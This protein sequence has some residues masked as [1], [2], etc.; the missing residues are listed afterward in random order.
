MCKYIATDFVASFWYPNLYTIIILR[1][2]VVN[3]PLKNIKHEKITKHTNHQLNRP[4]AFNIQHVQK[5]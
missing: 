3:T 2:Q 5:L 1:M 4:K